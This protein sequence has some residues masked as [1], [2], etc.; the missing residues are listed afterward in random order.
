MRTIKENMDL[1][2]VTVLFDCHEIL[3]INKKFNMRFALQRGYILLNC[4]QL[5]QYFRKL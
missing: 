4:V 5:L 2:G 1:V 3:W